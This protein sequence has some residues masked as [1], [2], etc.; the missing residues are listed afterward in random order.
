MSFVF[1]ARIEELSTVV[2]WCFE[3]G[4]KMYFNLYCIFLKEVKC[5]DLKYGKQTY[6]YQKGTLVFISPGQVVDVLNKTEEYQPMGHGLVF[7]P[8]LLL[9]TSL[10]SAIHNYNFLLL[11]RTRTNP[12]EY[13]TKPL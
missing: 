11:F 7:H 1:D 3:T 10:G 8:D 4:S 12:R 2:N 9:G 13:H 5:G 6:D